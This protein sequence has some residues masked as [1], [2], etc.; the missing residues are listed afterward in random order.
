MKG[1][2]INHLFHFLVNGIAWLRKEYSHQNLTTF[3]LQQH[4]KQLEKKSLQFTT[5]IQVQV[6]NTMAILNAIYKL[7]LRTYGLLIFLHLFILKCTCSPILEFNW[8]QLFV[9]TF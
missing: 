5:Q 8:F 6:I 9:V 2:S 3:Y 7:F 4:V 1:F